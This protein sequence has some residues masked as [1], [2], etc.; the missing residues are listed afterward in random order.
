MASDR[1]LAEDPVLAKAVVARGRR[2]D[3][4]IEKAAQ[5]A[6]P[7]LALADDRTH[8]AVR[9]CEYELR[10]IVS[11][12]LLKS[13]DDEVN[14]LLL[15]DSRGLWMVPLWPKQ[16]RYRRRHTPSPPSDGDSSLSRS[17]FQ[18]VAA[19]DGNS[20]GK[21]DLYDPANGVDLPSVRVHASMD[22]CHCRCSADPVRRPRHRRDGGAAATASTF[23]SRSWQPASPGS[24]STTWSG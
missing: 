4:L 23:L 2:V 22:E 19:L 13:S 12:P 14:V 5:A 20:L 16:W 10:T 7:S 9:R 1:D 17:L 24:K 18:A 15:P 8:R 11:L 3:Q 6:T 21:D